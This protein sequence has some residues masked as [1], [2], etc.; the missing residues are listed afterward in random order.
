M[1][2]RLPISGARNRPRAVSPRAHRSGDRQ[3]GGP[4]GGV[5]QQ[6]VGSS[7]GTAA[8]W[9]S[10]G[11]V[12]LRGD[13]GDRGDRGDGRHHA[14]GVV[15]RT[16][17][18]ES[19][20]TPKTNGKGSDFASANDKG[21]VGIITDDPTCDTWRRINDVVAAEEKGVSWPDRDQSVPATAVES[22]AADDVWNGRQ[23]N[24]GRRRSGDGNSKADASPGKSA[25]T[26]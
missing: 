5:P 26:V 4:P 13:G 23:G 20:K 6:P 11:Q 25:R 21:P 15:A 22:T 14:L 3:P 9:W 1:G 8:A 2:P 12:D 18:S 19:P 24:A 17:R 16:R 10:Q 7:A